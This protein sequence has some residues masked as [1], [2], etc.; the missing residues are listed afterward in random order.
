MATDK[1]REL[2]HGLQTAGVERYDVIME[3][4]VQRQFDKIDAWLKQVEKMFAHGEA[5]R[6]YTS[7]MIGVGAFAKGDAWVGTLTSQNT[8]MTFAVTLDTYPSEE[9]AIAGALKLYH[10]DFEFLDTYDYPM[11]GGW[12]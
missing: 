11:N 2:A 3:A 7:N 4:I 6:K 5:Y 1:Q 10:D 8:G 9:E 12:E